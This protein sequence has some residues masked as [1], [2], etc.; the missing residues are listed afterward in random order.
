MSQHHSL[1]ININ[2]QCAIDADSWQERVE[3][4]QT[5]YRLVSPPQTTVY[6]QVHTYLEGTTRNEKVLLN[7]DGTLEKRSSPPPRSISAW[8]RTL[9]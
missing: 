1:T 4:D 9:P 7:L 8:S 2:D 3:E 6:W 5:P